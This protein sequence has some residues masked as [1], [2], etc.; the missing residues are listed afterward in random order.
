MNDEHT[1]AR[2]RA[3]LVERLWVTG[4]VRTESVADA[5]SWVPREVFTPGAG[6][7]ARAY[8][9]R[10]VVLSTDERGLP[11]S[12]V[13]QPAMV[14]LMLEQLAVRPGMRVLEIGTGSGYN[15][16]LLAR[17]TGPEGE[18]V[19]V[20]VSAELAVA[21][22]RRLARLGTRVD[23]R[24]GD[25]WVGVADRAP[26]D[27]IEATVGVPDLPPAWVEQ[28]APD[29]VLV[30]P[31]WLRPGLE[32][33]VAWRRGTGGMLVSTSV[34]RCGFLQ[35]RGPHAGPGRTHALTGDLA[36][37]GEDLPPAALDVLRGLLDHGAV[38]AGPVLGPVDVRLTGFALAEPR[39]VLFL[40]HPGDGMTWGLFDPERPALAVLMQDRILVYGDRDAAVDLYYGVAGAPVV[41]ADRLRLEAIP[42]APGLP[43]SADAPNA[44]GR[45]W[46]VEREHYRYR[47]TET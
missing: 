14:A 42:V 11:D 41:N 2:L 36:V 24:T 47:L 44:G 10:V 29:G 26:F 19:S 27:R 43:D 39:S 8:E 18:V 21:A 9:D 28:L 37:I 46:T 33:A 5:M 38:D 3:A 45:T 25:G 32:L 31:M 22:A 23:V 1:A 17:L 35:L 12:T 15:A 7:L 4:S 16:A 40:G 34:A 13:S 20:E 30:A 6:S